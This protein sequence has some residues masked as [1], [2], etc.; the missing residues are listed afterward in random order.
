MPG[1]TMPNLAVVTRDYPDTYRMMTALGPLAA[2]V[3]VGSKGVMWKAQDE[4]EA[5]K[6]ELGTVTEVGCQPGAA[7][8]ANRQA[9]G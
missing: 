2:S 3:G 9:G 1:R 7:G 6:A 4:V 5:L 8:H